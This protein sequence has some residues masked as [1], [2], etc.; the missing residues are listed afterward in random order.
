MKSTV[1]FVSGILLSSLLA[2]PALCEEFTHGVHAG[3]DTNTTRADAPLKNLGIPEV[4]L[5]ADI[6]W[7][8]F[9]QETAFAQARDLKAKGYRVTVVF[10]TSTVPT[11]AQARAYFDWAQRQPG[12]KGAIDRWEILNE[13]NLSR[14]WKG[15]PQEY[16]N[17]VLKAAWDS[18]APNGELVVGA[19]TTTWQADA[20]GRY[21]TSHHYNQ[22]LKDAGY[23]NYLHYANVHPY[24]NN[25]A[26]MKSWL[27]KV[28]LIY[29]GKPI[30][31]TEFNFKAMSDHTL[32]GRSLEE[33]YPTALAKLKGVY[34]YR[35]LQS[36]SEGGWPGLLKT[37]YT[38]QN[39]FFNVW[40]D[41][42]RFKRDP[43]FGE[44]LFVQNFAASQ[45]VSAFVNSTPGFG[46]FDRLGW[47]SSGAGSQTINNSGLSVT[48]SGAGQWSAVRRGVFS[49]QLPL[50]W[51][52]E[53][54]ITSQ[55][56]GEANVLNLYAGSGFSTAA[57]PALSSRFAS[58]SISLTGGSTWYVQGRESQL[59]SGRQILRWYLNPTGSGMLYI[60]PSGQSRVL[61]PRTSDFWVGSVPISTGVPAPGTVT[62]SDI[63]IWSSGSATLRTS[64]L[65]DS[66]QAANSG[67]SPLPVPAS[68]SV[69]T[70]FL[71]QAT[72]G[73]AY[74]TT[75]AATGG[76]PPYTWTL[77]GGSLPPSLVLAANGTLSGT[78]S[79]RGSYSF[80]VRATDASQR[81]ATRTLA[82]TV[83]DPTAGI[84][85][86]ASTSAN[87]AN[88]VRLAGSRIAGNLYAFAEVAGASRVEFFLD[89]P[90]MNGTPLHTENNAPYDFAGSDGNTTTATARPYDTRRLSNGQHTI[91][92]RAR[93]GDGSTRVLSATFTVA[94]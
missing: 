77:A 22:A 4:R 68:L 24:T 54:E 76:T 1:W 17:N 62:A 25:A 75:L 79:A 60:D 72:A 40:K 88:P 69:A 18:L 36:A 13:V 31:A 87:R 71:P 86:L 3:V 44:V 49:S 43:S 92:A 58:Q 55:N 82:L 15:T 94:N 93:M 14:Y 52:F 28:S 32:W 11:Y 70:V 33:V 85:L 23:L 9:D 30:L 84:T 5:W 89:N 66:F 37:D 45:S 42:S 57:Q 10:N 7:D 90:A 64:M 59:F 41:L 38:P 81:Q 27:D 46:Q 29:A 73:K 61:Q 56:A 19:S 51:Q 39:V 53:L 74:S 78:P 91:S 26:T 67:N 34:F 83:T 50:L 16:V 21:S 35:L 20:S 80:T 8:R 12:L 48:K 47:S 2:L 63:A 65:F 6:N